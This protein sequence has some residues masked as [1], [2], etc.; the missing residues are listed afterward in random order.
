MLIGQTVNTPFTTLRFENHLHIS[1]SYLSKYDGEWWEFSLNFFV[2][3]QQMF[4]FLKIM[5]LILSSWFSPNDSIFTR[6]DNINIMKTDKKLM[7]QH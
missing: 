4:I 5:G 3:V 1:V 2:I 7:W 6:N